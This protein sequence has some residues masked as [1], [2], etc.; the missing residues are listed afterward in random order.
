MKQKQEYNQQHMY[1]CAHTHTPPHTQN[2][3][4]L[5]QSGFFSFLKVNQLFHWQII[6][7][8][9]NPMCW[10]DLVRHKSISFAEILIFSTHQAA[11]WSLGLAAALCIDLTVPYK[12]HFVSCDIKNLGM[13]ICILICI[14]SLLSYKLHYHQPEGFIDILS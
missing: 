1:M 2:L 5:Y 6:A 14:H 11:G 9:S 3:T 10:E 7:E 13:L 4:G 12:S 8:L